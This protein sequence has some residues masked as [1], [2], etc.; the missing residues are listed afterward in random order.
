VIFS[1]FCGR[2]HIF[3]K[4]AVAAG[5]VAD[6]DVGN[7]TDELAILNYRASAHSLSDSARLRDE[8]GVGH[9]DGEAATAVCRGV[10]RG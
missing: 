9:F 7:C 4:Y 10:D 1:F 6:E 5:G 3:D 8:G 2:E